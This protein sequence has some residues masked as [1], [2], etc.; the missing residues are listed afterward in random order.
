MKIAGIIAEYNPFHTG[1]AYHIQKTKELTGADYVIVVL[2]GDFVQRGAPALFSK[3]LRTQMA[4]LG[5]ADAV[6]ELPSTH[7]CESA[8]FFSQSAVHLLHSLGCVDVLSFGSE[9]GRLDDFLTVGSFLAKES[10]AYQELL[11]ENL[12]AGHSFPKARS[13]ALQ[14]SLSKETA[15]DTSFDDFLQTPNNILGIEYCKALFREESSILPFTIY[16]EGHGYHDTQISSHQEYPSA[17]AIRKLWKQTDGW[18]TPELSSCFPEQ[19]GAFLQQTF[20]T[21]AYLEEEDFSPYLRWLLFSSDISSF[22]AYQDVSEDFTNRLLRTHTSYTSWESYVTLLKTKELTYSRIS[23]M[24]MHMLLGITHVPELSYA[25]LL[26]FRRQSSQVL[27]LIKKNSCIPLLTKV[28]DASNLLEPDAWKLFEKN[29][30]ISNLYETVW[31][32]KYHTPFI[33]EYQKPIVIV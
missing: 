29:V 7:A 5:G 14:S 32:Q 28:S 10:S 2:S 17:S 18:N 9:S 16:R 26:G 6:F 4:L 1:H 21:P 24:L 11:K 3:H 20:P 8:E 22:S 30:Q 19:A 13:L 23:R 25:R 12:K 31:S 15:F 27:S 33:H